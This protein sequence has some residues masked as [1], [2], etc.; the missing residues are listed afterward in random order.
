M[1]NEEVTAQKEILKNKMFVLSRAIED[2]NWK[3]QALSEE[4]AELAMKLRKLNKE[5]ETK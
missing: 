2:L 4:K 5:D 3:K 1:P